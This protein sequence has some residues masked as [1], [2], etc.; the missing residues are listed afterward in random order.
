M[1]YAVK[2]FARRLSSSISAGMAMFIGV[3]NDLAFRVRCD[4]LEGVAAQVKFG[5]APKPMDLNA[6]PRRR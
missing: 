5:L 6:L 2:H 1:C 4:D 3:T